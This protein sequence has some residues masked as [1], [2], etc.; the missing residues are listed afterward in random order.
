MLET[1]DSGPKNRVKSMS[2]L[3]TTGD[4][5]LA[6]QLW[7][8]DSQRVHLYGELEYLAGRKAVRLMDMACLHSLIDETIRDNSFLGAI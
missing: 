2:P 6:G 7:T 4:E 3:T 8:N 5:V 1:M